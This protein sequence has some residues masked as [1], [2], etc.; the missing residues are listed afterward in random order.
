M[1]LISLFLL[2]GLVFTQKILPIESNRIPPIPPVTTCVNLGCMCVPSTQAHNIAVDCIHWL[3]PCYTRSQCVLRFGKCVFSNQ[4]WIRSCIKRYQDECVVGPCWSCVPRK[5]LPPP[6]IIVDCA[7][8]PGFQCYS[9]PANARCG[10][11]YHTGNC[12]WFK[13]YK[14]NRCWINS[15]IL[16]AASPISAVRT[17]SP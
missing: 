12:K 2:F 4:W 15:M 11:D 10:K 7:Y 13:S 9:D 8:N 17:E 1:K 6:G 3:L 16:E 5:D 14:F